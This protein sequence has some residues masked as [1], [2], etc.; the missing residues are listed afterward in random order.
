MSEWI[1]PTL[2]EIVNDFAG[3]ERCV[4]LFIWDA[5]RLG[6]FSQPERLASDSLMK[7]PGLK[8]WLLKANIEK[9]LYCPLDASGPNDKL[10]FPLALTLMGF[11]R[12]LAYGPF[13]EGVIRRTIGDEEADKRHVMWLPHA[14]DGDTFYELDRKLCRRLFLKHTGAQSMFAMLD[15]KNA[16]TP[17]IT[18]DETVV[19]IC[20]TN[21]S[22]KDFPLGLETCAILARNRKLRVWIHCDG[23]E[24]N[25][26]IPSLLVDYGLIG[27]ELL[28]LGYLP[29]SVMAEAYS[30]S[31]L[32]LGIGPEGFG[33]PAAESLACSTP[34]IS[35]SYAGAADFVP[36]AFQ[37]EPV[38]FRYEGSYSCKR[39]VYNATD[40]AEKAD[41]VLRTA[42]RSDTLL[43]SRYEWK[44]N[45]KAWEAWFREAAK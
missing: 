4:I 31:D 32:T 9:W 44:E 8:E 20:A 42:S 23:L 29:D 6:W 43:G 10:T 34:V 41:H 40:W 16:T 1:L 24:R 12:L 36:E 33:F 3:K 30:A 11:D 35:G 37:V 17:P 39:P 19:G 21:Q 13:G 25:W 38:A 15:P 18:E 7:F 14:I 2:P 5:S 26:S 28:T 45:W 22:R 27:K